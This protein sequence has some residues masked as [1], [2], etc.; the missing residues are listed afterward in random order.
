[1]IKKIYTNIIF[2]TFFNYP[3]NQIWNLITPPDSKNE[4]SIINFWFPLQPT[5]LWTGPQTELEKELQKFQLYDVRYINKQKM[6]VENQF[7]EVGDKFRVNG[8]IAQVVTLDKNDDDSFYFEVDVTHQDG[9]SEGFIDEEFVGT[10]TV[11]Q[12]L[13]LIDQFDDKTWELIRD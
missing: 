1:M 4:V 2:G 7:V 10:P 11:E 8:K 12:M 9:S 3:E 6:F 5:L 13:D